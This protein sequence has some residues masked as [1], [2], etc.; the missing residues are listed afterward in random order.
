M[1]VTKTCKTRL[2]NPDAPGRRKRRTLR[3][4]Q[5]IMEPVH[6][7]ASIFKSGLKKKTLLL[8][9]AVMLILIVVQLILSFF[10]LNDVLSQEKMYVERSFDTNIKTAVET[11][12]NA[13]EQNHQLYLD[14]II[15]EEVSIEIAKK[16]VRDTRYS[17]GVGHTGDGYFWADMADGY[18]AV[19]YNPANE[20]EMRYDFVDQEGTYYIR[21]FI[22]LGD[23]GG[24]YSDFYFGKP[25][26]ETGSHKK[27]GYTEKFEPYGWYISTGN[28]YDDTDIVLGEIAAKKRTDFTALAISSVVT[29]TIGLILVSMNLSSVV[30]PIIN[31]SRRVHRLSMGDTE[32]DSF[33]ITTRKDE[34]GD[35]NESISRV[36]HIL[37][38]LLKDI[39]DMIKEH[40]KGNIDYSFSTEEFFG[41]YNKLA[42]SV[43]ELASFSMRDQLTQIPNRRSFDNRLDLEWNRSLRDKQPVSVLMLDID[44]FKNYNDTFGHQQGDLTLQ[45][46]ASVIKK[47]LRR[48][49]DFVARW[50]GEEFVILLPS[51]DAPGAIRVAETVRT[52]IE[53]AVIPCISD[54]GSKVTVSIGVNTIS[55]EPED[56]IS[57]FINGADGALYEAK[58]QG[59]NRVCQCETG[60]A[61]TSSAETEE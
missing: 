18:C 29:V 34:I 1:F 28:Y 4:G 30:T 32:I 26:D 58:E 19:H 54:S 35:L 59:R 20:G 23:E 7:K 25:G 53:A 39:D 33:E 5:V 17:S 12:V 60:S 46:V 27:R 8:T 36:V 11:I 57:A 16:I 15:T 45:T 21:N 13:L 6:S 52:A 61:E 48:S 55:P 37:H 40:E 56:K 3:K 41:D 2:R 22:K 10:F 51:T 47:S 43:L 38:K 42:S 44:K 31:L 50:G 9:G 24:G 49:V 14:G